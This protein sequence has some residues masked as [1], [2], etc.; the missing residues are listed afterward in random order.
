MRLTSIRHLARSINNAGKK[1]C[2]ITQ[3]MLLTLSG[4]LILSLYI[5]NK[6]SFYKSYSLDW[7]VCCSKLLVFCGCKEIVL[8]L[9]L[10]LYELDLNLYGLVLKLYGLYGFYSGRFVCLSLFVGLG[11][12]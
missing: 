8:G 10:S 12:Q 6:V 11:D 4:A 7:V 9:V 5:F 1:K 3:Q 2:Y